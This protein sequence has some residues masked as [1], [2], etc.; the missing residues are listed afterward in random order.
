[1]YKEVKFQVS[2]R[3]SVNTRIIIESNSIKSLVSEINYL[4]EKLVMSSVN[5]ISNINEKEKKKI[6]KLFK[7][8]KLSLKNWRFYD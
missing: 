2:I 7:K 1:M 3:D 5:F 8:N 6:K 4:A